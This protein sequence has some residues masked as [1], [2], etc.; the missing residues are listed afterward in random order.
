VTDLHAPGQA[1]QRCDGRPG[2]A[3]DDP[4]GAFACSANRLSRATECSAYGFAGAACH[5]ARDRGSGFARAAENLSEGAE[6]T[7]YD[8]A[9]T[10]EDASGRLARTPDG[11]THDMADGFTRTANDASH[12]ASGSSTTRQ[13][14]GNTY[15]QHAHQ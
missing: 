9:G 10:A 8:F 3:F 11:A 7:G 12:G 14:G 6:R 5:A 2:G 1:F 15:A 4:D 13:Y